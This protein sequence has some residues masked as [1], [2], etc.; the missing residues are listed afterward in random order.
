[1]SKELSIALTS[2]VTGTT[3]PFG[4]A[5]SN[6]FFPDGDKKEGVSPKP[7]A[8]YLIYSQ[9]QDDVFRAEIDNI[10]VQI[11]NVS[12]SNSK[13]EVDTNNKLAREL[14]NGVKLTV[15]GNVGVQLIRMNQIPALKSE[16]KLDWISTIDFR[17]KM[18]KE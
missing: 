16:D 9:V 18:Q 15:T 4:T 13:G 10:M 1:M 2:L 3:N 7:Y 14:L 6:R 17:T 5:I 12:D 8:T 11:K